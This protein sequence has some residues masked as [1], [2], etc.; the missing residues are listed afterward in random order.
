MH[1]HKSKI[2]EN[3]FF[4]FAWKITII[5]ASVGKWLR[6]QRMCNVQCASYVMHTEANQISKTSSTTT[7]NQMQALS[8][9]TTHYVQCVGNNNY[10]NDDNLNGKL[11]KPS[12]HTYMCTACTDFWCLHIR[13]LI[14]FKPMI[15]FAVLLFKTLYAIVSAYAYACSSLCL[16]LCVCADYLDYIMEPP[17]SSSHFR[18]AFGSMRQEQWCR[19]FWLDT[20]MIDG[21]KI[22][23]VWMRTSSTHIH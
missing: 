9:H 7:I 23:V 6:W 19:A 17:L 13:V 1:Q 21:T 10:Y 20:I 2:A 18:I 12:I 8:A 11:M 5:M 4:P 16:C 15:W 14:Q 22:F 3:S